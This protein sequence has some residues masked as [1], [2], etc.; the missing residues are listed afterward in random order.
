M[1]VIHTPT[2]PTHSGV[3]FEGLDRGVVLFA[4]GGMILNGLEASLVGVSLTAAAALT[5]GLARN[6]IANLNDFECVAILPAPPGVNLGR[7]ALVCKWLASRHTFDGLLGDLVDPD[8]GGTPE[9]ARQYLREMLWL[10]IRTRI[11]EK[12]LALFWY[13][14]S[15]SQHR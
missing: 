4:V 12:I 10:A 5:Y 13:G 8:I 14:P 2:S 9:A 1:S 6:R 11:K 3:A 7:F 15:Q